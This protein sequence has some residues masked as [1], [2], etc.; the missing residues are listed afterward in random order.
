[1]AHRPETSDLRPRISDLI[2]AWLAH[3]FT[4]SGVLC[5]FFATTSIF[6]HDYRAAFYWMAA[7]V[8][9][10]AVD[11]VLARRARVKEVL[12]WFNGAKMDDIIDYG[13]YVFVP[14]LF[15]WRALLVP[16]AWLLPV[17]A[18]M[19]LSSLY[20]FNTDKAKTDDHYFTGFPSYW[21]IVVLYMYL[22]GWQP[23]VNAAVLLAL[24]VL[25][26]VPLK[27]IYPSRMTRMAVPTNVL[28]VVWAG[29]ML[30]MLWRYPA[31]PPTL[32]MASWIFPVYY[33]GL[34][35]A[36]NCRRGRL[37]GQST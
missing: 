17:V 30:V 16:D 1:V 36:L 37:S 19:L 21:N 9:I 28:G 27:W 18:A 15:V 12:P 20:G 34:S 13:S 26:F 4:A 33:A 3:L 32:F 11:G 14:A 25:V 6:E 10:D 22:G 29:L 5:V 35:L 24:A 2:S 7:Q 31:V 8:A 23:E